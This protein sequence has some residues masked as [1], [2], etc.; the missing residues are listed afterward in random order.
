MDGEYRSLFKNLLENYIERHR[1][2]VAF[3]KRAK[4]TRSVQDVA[5]RTLGEDEKEL[6]AM[7]H[8]LKEWEDNGHMPTTKAYY[9][10]YPT[11]EY[12]LNYN[13]YPQY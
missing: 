9:H 10:G 4:A 2:E 12:Y 1:A 3:F 6:E 5:V 7:Q 11:T 8:F 13:N